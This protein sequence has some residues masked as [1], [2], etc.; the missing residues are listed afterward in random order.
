MQPGIS[1][2]AMRLPGV[3]VQPF[4]FAMAELAKLENGTAL[5]KE[6]DLYP[7]ENTKFVILGDPMSADPERM[8]SLFN[9]GYPGAPLVGGMASGM[10]LH[11]PP[12]LLLGSQ[13]FKHGLAGVALVGTLDIQT[14]VAQGCH[15]RRQVSD[16]GGVMLFRR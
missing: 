13:V 10:I 3:R 14:V 9:E 1:I 4:T 7:N 16:P 2:L 12:W 5:V 8:T 6:L 11:K 15:A